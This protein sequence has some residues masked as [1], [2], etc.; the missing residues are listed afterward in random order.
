MVWTNTVKVLVSR[1]TLYKSIVK[2]YCKGKVAV[3]FTFI[4]FEVY[5]VYQE[6]IKD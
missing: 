6:F 5:S 2:L 3:L 1:L 4:L